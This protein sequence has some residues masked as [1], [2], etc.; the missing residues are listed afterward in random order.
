[1]THTWDH[2]KMSVDR[3]A[4][5]HFSFHIEVSCPSLISVN[6]HIGVVP[7]AITVN[8]VNPIK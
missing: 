8:K 6:L 4:P 7:F 5:E 1:M 3:I 2:V